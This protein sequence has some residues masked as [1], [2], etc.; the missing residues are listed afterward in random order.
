MAAKGGRDRL[1]AIRNFV[2]TSRQ[3][4]S[5]SPRPEVAVYEARERLAV[6]PDKLW[7][8]TDYRPGLMKLE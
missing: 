6:L 5:R 4:F 3:E 8:Y 1:R 2:V 7:E